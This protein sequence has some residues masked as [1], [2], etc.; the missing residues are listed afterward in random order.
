L[1]L[2]ISWLEDETLEDSSSILALAVLAPETM[3]NP[4]MTLVQ[5]A[6]IAEELE[7]AEQRSHLR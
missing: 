2:D 6:G 1:N 4:Q 3:D 7:I 5:F